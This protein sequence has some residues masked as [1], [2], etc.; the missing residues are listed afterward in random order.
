MVSARV[1]SELGIRVTTVDREMLLERK[2]AEGSLL[3]YRSWSFHGMSENDG[4]VWSEIDVAVN[5]RH[6]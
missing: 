6:P 5:S 4:K 3:V 2:A 1:H